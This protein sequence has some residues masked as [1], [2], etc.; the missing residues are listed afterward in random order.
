MKRTKAIA[1]AILPDFFIQ[2][3]QA[4]RSRRLQVRLLK[5]EGLLDAAARYIERNGCTIK[6]GPFA[7]TIYSR[8]AA[9]CRI[10]IPK[11]LGTYEQE[12]HDI[13]RLIGQRKY[14]LVIDIGSAEGYYAVGLARLLG[15]KVLAY[16]PEPIERAF[17]REAARLNGVSELVELK[18]LFRPSDIGLFRDLRVLCVCD[19]EGFEA[20][21]FN[22]KT[23]QGV[24]KWDLLIEMH[25]QAALELTSLAWPNKTTEIFMAPRSNTYKELDGLGDQQK[26]LSEYRS[27]TQTWLW[28]DSQARG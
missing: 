5:R 1:R 12:L 17:C 18:D 23:V 16:D 27:G 4:I 19:C 24:G 21:I 3:V 11:L 13:L 22:A 20:E 28:C 25:G 14:D 2:R 6:Y 8:E 10:S 9:L 26:L 7:G 15:T